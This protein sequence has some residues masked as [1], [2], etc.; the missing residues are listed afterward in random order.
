[1]IAITE[2]YVD[3]AALNAAAIKNGKD[4]V[5]KKSFTQLC[6]TEDG[7]LLFGECKGSGK[8]PYRCSADW[9]K[10]DS[11]VYR[12][13]CP[14]RQ[15]PCKHI[16]GLMYA[17]TSGQTFTIEELPADIS[18]KREKADKREEKKKETAAAG[19]AAP[20]KRKTGKAALAK[21]RKA[22]LEGID[23]LEKLVKQTVQHGLASLDAGTLKLLSGQAK[24]LG[25]YYIPGVQ[26]AFRELLDL[27]SD[28][29]EREKVYTEVI[30]RLTVL[31]SLVKRSR[32]YLRSRAEDPELP[33]ETQTPLEEWLGHAWQL[34]ELRELGLVERDAELLQLA[35]RSYPD[36]ARGEYVDE[37]FWIEPAGGRIGATRHYRPFRAA[38]YIKEDDTVS[39]VV[40]TRE[41][42]LYPGG[43]NRRIRWEDMTMRAAQPSDFE[44]IRGHACRS[45]TEAAKTVKNQL[46]NPL[47]D[48]HPV[49]LLHYAGLGKVEDSWVI[50]DEQGKRLVLT[51]SGQPGGAGTALLAQL[52]VT[53][54]RGGVML[55]MFSH[56]W[57]TGRLLAHPLS[58]LSGGGV[59]RLVY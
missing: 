33:M 44:R 37:G 46:K 12:C 47:A 54:T 13:S 15:F 10:E 23:L 5:R 29:A 27:L 40:Q 59:I 57:S 34:A 38:K 43:I 36:P 14:S 30:D 3:S 22:Q 50:E 9:I 42:F 20:A 4:L 32:E 41:L 7:T 49:L 28:A 8:E 45:Y 51:D 35:F 31:H 24:E 58:V 56:D 19:E 55:V 18:D 25:N 16:L 52:D 26:S 39:A 21:K 17:Y 48:K 53:L 1:M 2:A 11:P 6:R